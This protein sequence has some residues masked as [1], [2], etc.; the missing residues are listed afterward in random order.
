MKAAIVG[1]GNISRMHFGAISEIEDVEIVAVADI[2][3]ERADKKAAEYNAKAYYDFDEML[4]NEEI[5][6]LHICTPHYLHT[7]MAVK[8]LEKGIN[9]LIEKPCSVS[10][11]EVE[12]LRNAQKN[13]GKQI[14]VCFQNRYNS[15]SIAVKNAIDNK[16]YGDISSI[17]AFLTWN[18]GKDYYSDD[19]HGTKEKECGGVLIN[20]A[21]H[22][23]D[24]IQYFG[25]GCE[26]VTAHTFNDHLKGIIEVEDTATVLMKLKDDVPAVLYA[27]LAYGENSDVIIEIAFSSGIK[28]RLEGEKLY[29]ID[30]NGK[31]EEILQK[32]NKSY[33]GQTYWGHGH[34][35]LISD[36]YD[37]LKTGRHFEIDAFEGGKAALIV[38]ESYK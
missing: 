27:T 18:R 20:Q 33:V 1:C 36:W 23:I 5:D 38:A 17:R 35:S 26:K 30:E 25:G 24:L 12:I 14:A 15:G 3:K 8:A 6:S 31:F 28:L 10:N 32:C 22:T 16:T 19:W 7:Q 2:K 37:C 13:S 4:N 29:K 21:I 9:V 11:E 34:S